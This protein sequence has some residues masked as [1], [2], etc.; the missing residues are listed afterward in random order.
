M[1]SKLTQYTMTDLTEGNEYSFRV[2]AINEV[3]EGP[4]TE[5]TVVAKDRIGIVVHLIFAFVSRLLCNI[6][7]QMFSCFLSLY[8]LARLQSQRLS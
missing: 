4:P 7:Y 5:L 6:V 1:K 8:S 3:A 2:K